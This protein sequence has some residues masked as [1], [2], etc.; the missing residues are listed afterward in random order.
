MTYRKNSLTRRGFV[1]GSIGAASYIASPF[2]RKAS[3]APVSI[4]YATGGGIGPNEMETLI[5]L[6]WMQKNVLQGYGKDYTVDMTFTRGT[7]EAGTLLAAGQADIAT[8][9]FA[10][11][12][13]SVLRNTVPNGMTIV[14][15]NYQDGKP[16][17][18]QN[19]FFVLKDSPIKNTQNL[20]GKIIG[21]NAFGSAVDLAM[22]VK[23]KTEGIDPRSDVQV[24]EIAFANQASALREKRID[25]G[26]LVLPFMNAETLKGDLR[27]LFTGGDAF[28]GPYSVIFQVTTNDFLKQHPEAVKAY[29]ADYVRGLHW[30]YDPA[31]RKKAIEIAS[32]FT[33]SPVDVLDSYFMT[34]RDY[35]RDPNGC[36]SLAAIQTP[37]DAMLRVGF[38]DKPVNIAD[39]LHMSYLPYP[40][41]T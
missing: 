15:D 37:V 2:I 9:S 5:Y 16:G 3:A 39:H 28:G 34:E 18:A 6:D 22:R 36:V 29:L 10:V 20:K 11:F 23:L 13:T 7:P 12:A 41:A 19:T 32:A 26:V 33:K 8:L 35:F 27:V 14:S 21:V 1:A 24:V 38:I 40:C 17:Y 31:N 30:F 25:C 4:R